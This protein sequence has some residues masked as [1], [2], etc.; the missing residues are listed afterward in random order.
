MIGK[1]KKSASN[2]NGNKGT[3]E[4]KDM[5]GSLFENDKKTSDNHPDMVGVVKIDGVELRLA[6][7]VKERDGKSDWISLSVSE[8][9]NPN[10]A[11]ASSPK[12]VSSKK[13]YEEEVDDED[14]DAETDDD[15]DEDDD[16]VEEEDLTPP[17]RK[18]S[19]TAVK[20]AK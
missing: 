14:D 12:K 19:K 6:G 10:D 16:D 9:Q 3:F 11:P 1:N 13:K 4:R 15:T 20:Q 8:F 5:S 7:W 2:G 18:S 17:K